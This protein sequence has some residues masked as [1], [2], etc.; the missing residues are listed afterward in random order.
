MGKYG[1]FYNFIRYTNSLL[2]LYWFIIPL[3]ESLKGLREVEDHIAVFLMATYGEGEPTDNAMQFNDF[4]K[5]EETDLD[6]L[7][8]AVSCQFSVAKCYI[9]KC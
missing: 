6:G 3:Q 7:N 8:F 9:V 4:I 1:R 2:I 5:D